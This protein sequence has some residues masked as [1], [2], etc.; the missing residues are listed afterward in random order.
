MSKTSEFSNLLTF[1]YKINQSCTLANQTEKKIPHLYFENLDALRFLAAFS[2]FFFHYSSDMRA[3]FSNLGEHSV[4]K[5]LLSIAE[6]G[7]LGVN[8][9]FVLSGFLITYLIMYEVKHTGKFSLGKFLIRRTLRIWPLYF[10][11]IL[12]S[13]VLFPVILDGYHTA[14]NPWMY[15][16]FLANFD[17]INN[18]LNDSLNFLT[19]LWS[20][21][22]EEQFYLFWGLALFVLYRIKKINFPLLIGI[23]FIL[24]FIFRWYHWDEER[25]IYYHTFSV[26]QDI[27]TGAFI[28]WSL[29]EGKRWLDKIKDLK[30]I[31]VLLIYIA[32]FAICIAKNKIFA[33]ELIIIERFVLSLFFGFIILDQ[34]R[35]ANSIYK[36]GKVKVFNY[37]GKI[38]YGLYMYHMVILFCVFAWMNSWGVES[39]WLMPIYFALCLVLT[40]SVASLSYYLIE[41]PLL[42][43]KP[44]R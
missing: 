16:A 35:G 26:C 18:G 36:L 43:L 3:V 29:F 38:S 32:G 41:K 23:I 31:W 6:K 1:V 34:I 14:H 13:F 37:L 30:K 33:D 40:I 39:Y 7:S 10:I 24:S 15:I 5:A 4:T 8:F 21:A 12:I 19:T 27:L 25:T 20:V 11:I 22:V 2:V 17:E 9:F 42:K 44:K 28:A